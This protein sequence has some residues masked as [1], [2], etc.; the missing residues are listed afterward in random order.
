MKQNIIL[1][2][3]IS[4]LSFSTYAE[5][6]SAL[7]YDSVVEFIN[8]Y[9]KE[10]KYSKEE[11]VEYFA[12]TKIK[13]SI[14]KESQNQPE[15]KMNWGIYEKKV[16]TN[17]KIEKGKLF[18]KNNYKVLEKAED[19][20][21]VPK[22]I[23][24]SIIGIESFYGKYK[25]SNKAIDSISTMAFEGSKRRQVFFR[26]ELISF[27]DF[28]Y[29]NKL[30][31]LSL[32]SS[33]AGAF[34]YPQFIPSS[35]KSYAVDFNNDGVV[36]LINC[37]EDAIGS[38]ANYLNRKGWI[39]NNYIAEPIYNVYPNYYSKINSFK[40]D[41]DL[42]YFKNKGAYV[43]RNMRQTKKAKLIEFEKNNTKEYWV[44]YN[45]F[46]TIT[47]YNRSNLYAMAVFVLANEIKGREVL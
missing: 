13:K 42:E 26:N 4:S 34:G 40:L 10:N 1:T 7:S 37:K 35:I 12:R 21:G 36:D 23:I 38:V 3:I 45:N 33:W 22:E 18:L 39:E 2:L 27:F 30:D 43:K 47:K 24:V 5:E 41:K 9:S 6:V 31:P 14:V 15:V 29:N 16:V 46:H 8:D 17:E 19:T 44:G 25:G 32:K 28:S 20:Y 11:L